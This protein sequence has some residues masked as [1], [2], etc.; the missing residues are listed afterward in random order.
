MDSD[1]LPDDQPIFDQFLDLLTG[2]GIGD[3]IGLIGVQTD[4]CFAIA[5][6]TGGKPLLK[7]EHAHGC[8]CSDKRKAK[9]LCV[10]REP[11]KQKEGRCPRHLC[12]KNKYSW[13][14]PLLRSFASMCMEKR[15]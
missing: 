2:V 1:R 10:S 14:R 6:D 11:F 5:E 3:F 7:P 13:F 9:G 12:V 15:F 4:I 8:G